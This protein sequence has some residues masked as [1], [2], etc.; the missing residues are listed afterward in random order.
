MANCS[1]LHTPLL[2]RMSS[3]TYNTI[4]FPIYKI[5]WMIFNK[6]IATPTVTALLSPGLIIKH[7][8]CPLSHNGAKHRAAQIAT[9]PCQ[10][11]LLLLYW[12]QLGARLMQVN[13]NRIG[14]NLPTL[15]SLKPDTIY[16]IQFISTTRCD[17]LS[18]IIIECP[19]C[20]LLSDNM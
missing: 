15:L 11:S 12:V 13:T 1:L 5:H 3:S 2:W 6:K 9:N 4:S 7:Y 20:Q 19:H 14:L 16:N 10:Q 18:G 8:R 17:P